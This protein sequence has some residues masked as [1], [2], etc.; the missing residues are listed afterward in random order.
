MHL[1]LESGWA[2]DEDSI[3]SLNDKLLIEALQHASPCSDTSNIAMKRL[4][5]LERR[6]AAEKGR[7]VRG[8]ADALQPVSSSVRHLQSEAH[9]SAYKHN[10]L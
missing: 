7:Q 5:D 4:W 1:H 2:K 3:R 9:R 8:L 10:P 6:S